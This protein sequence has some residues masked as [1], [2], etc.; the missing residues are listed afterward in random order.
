MWIP[1][2]YKV[3]KL[4]RS[5][6]PE[7]TVTKREWIGLGIGLFGALIRTFSKLWIGN[8]FAYFLS[9]RK[10]QKLITNGP[11]AIVRHPGYT[12]SALQ[13]W[14]DSIYWNTYISY[15]WAAYFSVTLLS[16]I[17]E[18]EEILDDAFQDEWDKYTTKTK[19]KLLP[20]IY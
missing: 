13:L 6:N 16:R 9:I 2:A 15:V 19:A 5:D 18:E 3:Y 12:G 11:Y 20:F 10:D 8:S 7:F 1:W 17:N 14:G 4:Y